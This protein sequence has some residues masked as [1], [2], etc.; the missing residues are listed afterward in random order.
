MTT[1][2]LLVIIPSILL[3]LTLTGCQRSQVALPGETYE[4]EPVFTPTSREFK[5][6]FDVVNTTG[7]DVQILMETA[8]SPNSHAR[9]LPGI[10]A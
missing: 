6:T 2:C 3:S 5:H 1:D 4:A 10:V 9:S 7:R 8:T